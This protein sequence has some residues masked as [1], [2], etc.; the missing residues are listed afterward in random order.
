MIDVKRTKE[1]EMMINKEVLHQLSLPRKH[2]KEEG[3]E[4]QDKRA[5]GPPQRYKIRMVR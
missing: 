3:K 5:K 1:G 4:S 2:P